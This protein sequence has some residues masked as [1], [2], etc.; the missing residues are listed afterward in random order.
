MLNYQNYLNDKDKEED[1]EVKDSDQKH[2]TARN[3]FA[4]GAWS[5]F[6]FLW[7]LMLSLILS[8]TYYLALHFTAQRNYQM[9]GENIEMFNSL[10]RISIVFCIS[11][12][13]HQ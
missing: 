4:H 3:S 13:I 8:L 6:H 7:I 12:N 1:N 2:N 5:R 11:A 10:L 9:V